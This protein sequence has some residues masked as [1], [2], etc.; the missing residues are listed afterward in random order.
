MEERLQID[1]TSSVLVHL[2]CPAAHLQTP[3]RFNRRCAERGINAVL[4]PWQVQ[5]DNL[6]AMMQALR[7]A[8]SVAGMVVTIPH[9]ET[10]ARLCDRLEGVADL[11]Q[12]ANVIRREADGSLTGR[13]LDGDGFVG[14]LRAENVQIAGRSALIVGAGGVALAIGAAL[15][16]SGVARLHIANRTQA[17]AEEMRA[18]LALLAE[19]IGARTDLALSEPDPAG[20]DIVVN[21]TALGMYDGDALPV[22]PD[23]LT[24]QMTVAEVVMVPAITPLLRAAEARGARTVPGSAMIAGQIDPFIDFVLTRRKGGGAEVSQ[25]K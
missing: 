21:A 15:I 13:I 25:E 4:V 19:K 23:R 22:S 6:A 7:N 24:P 12:V 14:G 3:Q 5:P 8:E 1:G 20:F 11:L 18:R 16:E 9:K 17:R 2:A 10:A